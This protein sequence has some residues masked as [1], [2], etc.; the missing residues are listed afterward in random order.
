MWQ[1]AIVSIVLLFAFSR[2]SGPIVMPAL[3]S[4]LSPLEFVD[5]MGELY[6]RA[7]AASVAVEVPYR[8]LRLD[9]ARRLGRPSTAT[10]ADLARAAAQRLSL[11]EA[12]IAAT[13][14]AAGDASRASKLAPKQAL[15]LVQK[16]VRYTQQLKAPQFRQEK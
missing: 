14:N 3:R 1:L 12:E 8:R 7:G 5:T 16:L 2:R 6:S 10:D 4:R 11:P 13:L 15:D 9:L